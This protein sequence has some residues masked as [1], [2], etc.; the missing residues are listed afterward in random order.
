MAPVAFPVFGGPVAVSTPE[1]NRYVV[2]PVWTGWNDDGVR[3]SALLRIDVDSGE[4][5]MTE[6]VFGDT[7]FGSFLSREGKLYFSQRDQL[8][9][10]DARTH[11]L[12][13]LGKIPTRMPLWFTGDEKGR[14]WFASHP[15]AELV[16]YDP[17]TKELKNHGAFAKETWPQYAYIA[18]DAQGWVYAAI[19]YNAGNLVGYNPATGERRTFLS[20]EERKYTDE[21]S[22]YRATD[23]AVYAKLDSDNK[24]RKLENGTMTLVKRP[25]PGRAVWRTAMTK[26]EAF[27]DG[28]SFASVNIPGRQLTVRE[29]DGSRRVV[30]FDYEADGARIYSLLALDN[31]IYGSTGLPP[32]AFSLDAKTGARSGATVSSV[33]HM[34]VW[35]AQGG[36]VYGGG[37]SN[38][39]LYEYDPAANSFPAAMRMLTVPKEAR[40][41]VGRPF[42]M[43]AHPDG[44][45]VIMTGNPSRALAGGG[46]LIL[47]THTSESRLITHEKLA[48]GHG[49]KSL[50]ALPDG[51]LICGTTTQAATAGKSEGGEAGLI[52]LKWPGMEVVSRW[53]PL[54]QE[55]A[56]ND[57][58]LA[59]DGRLFGLADSRRLFVFDPAKG[60]L[61]RTVLLDAYG[62]NTGAPGN[63]TTNVLT[64]G[65]DGALYAMFSRHIVRVDPLT[66]QH[67]SVHESATVLSGALIRA[68]R[69]LWFATG[70]K[71]LSLDFPDES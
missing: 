27:S 7:A 11:E 2:A 65:P 19:R 53:T 33:L 21:C 9:E 22:I 34:N 16:S 37:Y 12:H 44:R 17:A 59:P 46:M 63:Q 28:S 40:E 29:L 56:I 35:A 39:A 25:E 49:I 41:S 70:A 5:R 68:D 51:D 52:R 60:K 10:Y 8:V 66:L 24:W 50:A 31:S 20:A 38:G 58:V 15:N 42:E 54:K 30:N 13:T 23:G 48:P 47:D 55:T 36:K 3:S 45:H 4:T 18:M 64:F 57:L 71:L 62:E 1:G 61:L 6:P 14:I 26:P 32:V 67:R 43:I 69:R